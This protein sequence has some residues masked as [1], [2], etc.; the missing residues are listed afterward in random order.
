LKARWTRRAYRQLEAALTFV[1]EENPIAAGQIAQCIYNAERVLCDNPMVGRLGRVS[2]TREWA[3]KGAPYLLGYSVQEQYL[4][5][6]ALL[7]SK[8]QWPNNFD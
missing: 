5:I 3:I 4:V 1:A 2:G 8:Q 6:L 7:H